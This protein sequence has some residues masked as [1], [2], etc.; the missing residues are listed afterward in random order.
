MKL[1]RLSARGLKGLFHYPSG[2]TI[3]AATLPEGLIALVGPNG[4]GKTSVIESF[5]ATLYGEFPSR[6]KVALVDAFEG[7]DGYLETEFSEDDGTRCRIRVNVDAVKRVSDGVIKIVTADDQ[8]HVNDGKIS[9]MRL[10][11]DQ[12]LPPAA[13]VLASIFHAQNRYGAF[14]DLDKKGRRDLF[15]QLLGLDRYEQWAETARAKALEHEKARDKH[16]GVIAHLLP[17]TTN[18]ELERLEKLGNDLQAYL[19]TTEH[20]LAE[21]EHDVA[22]TAEA[23]A[24]ARA[25]ADAYTAAVRA[26]AQS[27]ALLSTTQAQIAKV[28]A[29]VVSIAEAHEAGLAKIYTKRDRTKKELATKIR[30]QQALIARGD[31]IRSAEEQIADLTAEVESRKEIL[32]AGRK[33]L[34]DLDSELAAAALLLRPFAGVDIKLEQARTNAELLTRVP[35]G[36]AGDFAACE[37]LVSAKAAEQTIPLLERTQSERDALL[38]KERHLQE[39]RQAILPRIAAAEFDIRTR[40]D[41]IASLRPTARLAAAL[42]AAEARVA[43]LQQEIARAETECVADVQDLTERT[44]QAIS[45]AGAE[46]AGAELQVSLHEGDIETHEAAK[47]AHESAHKELVTAETNADVAR[48]VSVACS[49]DRARV[50]AQVVAFRERMDSF[51]QKREQR[52]ALEKTVV[53]VETDLLEWQ[54][55]AKLCGREGLPMLEIDAAGPQV[56]ALANDLLSAC[57]GTRFTLELITQDVKKSD[58]GMKE[59]FELRVWDA[60]RGGEAKDISLL[61]GGEKVIVEEALKSAVALFVNRRNERPLRTAFRDETTGALDPDNALH[62]V[63]MLRRLQERGGFSRIF[64][65]SHNPEVYRLADAQLVFTPGQIRTA[66]P[67]YAED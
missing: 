40:D 5:F 4:M 21:A 30:D 64:F 55:L 17:E 2:I 8:T 25:G 41:E 59:V 13:L 1:E 6:H 54:V 37:L 28:K 22:V 60:D 24:T 14:S 38:A 23:L 10:L 44:G 57:F 42:T 46:L 12:Y 43:E 19:S 61:S 35:C 47:R 62:Y 52:L 26:L 49:A 32:N 34:A 58:K 31:S 9:T 20:D 51:Q 3:D 66:L 39:Q 16:A 65:V 48:R 7:K 11:A 36:G 56:S 45:T 27:Q 63:E 18:E 50:Q 67:P 15:A 33:V 29:R 53:Q